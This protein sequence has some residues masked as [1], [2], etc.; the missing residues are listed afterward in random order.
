MRNHACRHI[1]PAAADEWGAP[2]TCEHHLQ[3][4]DAGSTP[5]TSVGS[6][7]EDT[8]RYLDAHQHLIP[9]Q[10]RRAAPAGART[11]PLR[12]SVRDPKTSAYTLRHTCSHRHEA[13][14]FWP[15][16]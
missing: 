6:L 7:S 1:S 8:L 3:G 2:Q 16:S 11:A 14:Q 9:G 4:S 15:A 10:K 12:R 5:A 13:F